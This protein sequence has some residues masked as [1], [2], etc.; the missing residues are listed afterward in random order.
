MKRTSND[1]SLEYRALDRRSFLI[2]A[3]GASTVTSLATVSMQ[4]ATGRS[5]SLTKEQ[6]IQIC[7]VMY[8]LTNG[9]AEFLV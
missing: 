3:F 9:V 6:S 4:L 1:L 2:T 5:G 7:G 8:N